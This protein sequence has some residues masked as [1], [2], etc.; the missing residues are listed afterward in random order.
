[1]RRFAL[2]LLLA[3]ALLAACH[4][5]ARETT[6]PEAAALPAL[7]DAP[8]FSGGNA[9]AHCGALC[10]MGPRP[11]GSAAYASQLDYLERHLAAAG[12]RVHRES[13]SPLPGMKMVN[14]HACFGDAE[15]ATGAPRGRPLLVTCHVDTKAGI[16]GFVGADDGA[17]GAAVMLELARVLAAQAP[18]RARQ[19][20]LLFLDGE[21]AF[22]AHMTTTD[23]IYGSRYDVARRAGAL[24]RWQVNLDMVGGRD[25]LIA[26]PALDMSGAMYEIYERAV[27]D[28]K[29]SP[30]RWSVYPGSYFDDHIPYRLAGVESL[31]LIAHFQEGNWW[32]TTKD[33]FSRISARSLEESGRFVYGLI[34]G[35]YM[36]P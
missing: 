4:D 20:E 25:M 11:S 36:L 33:D 1:M 6:V 21:E 32:H 24:P 3:C 35:G 12:W 30:R 8:S 5:G 28:L 15:D 22:G 31:N 13:F 16:P 27:T 14:L 17:S 2:A 34:C 18:E 10:A 9:Y 23:G 19:V 26:P 29:M 7:T